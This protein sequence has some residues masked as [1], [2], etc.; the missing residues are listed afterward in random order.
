MRLKRV[1]PHHR[2][3]RAGRYPLRHIWALI[4]ISYYAT[5]YVYFD[6]YDQGSGPDS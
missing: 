6:D 1:P 2:A 5:N 3:Q 4:R